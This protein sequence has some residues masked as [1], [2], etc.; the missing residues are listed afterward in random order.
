MLFKESLVEEQRRFPLA[1]TSRRPVL[2]S[3][4]PNAISAYSASRARPRSP[5]R[6][7]PLRSAP[8]L[9]LSSSFP[10]PS[11]GLIQIII[12][13]KKSRLRG[14]PH[15]SMLPQ[16]WVGVY[17]V[18][19]S[20]ENLRGGTEGVGEYHE[21]RQWNVRAGLA[22]CT[23]KESMVGRARAPHFLRLSV[24]RT[25]S[26]SKGILTMWKSCQPSGEHGQQRARDDKRRRSDS[27]I[28]LRRARRP[29]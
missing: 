7:T 15:P 23:A 2:P 17:G 9:L 21:M 25:S 20:S 14:A 24:P 18:S 29:P 10:P 6:L 16:A 11:S 26:L 28:P 8:P 19:N 22:F 27:H 5:A 3:L 4:G 1:S 13:S 12:D